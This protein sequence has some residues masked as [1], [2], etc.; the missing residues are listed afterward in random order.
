[1]RALID[2]F[3][4]KREVVGGWNIVIASGRFHMGSGGRLFRRFFMVCHGDSG[5]A[6]RCGEPGSGASFK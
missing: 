5:M 6:V 2:W 1:M 3:Q 4:P